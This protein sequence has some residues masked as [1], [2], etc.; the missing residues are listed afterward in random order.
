MAED[1][2]AGKP[3]ATGAVATAAASSTSSSTPTATPAGHAARRLGPVRP[4]TSD[5]TRYDNGGPIFR[6]RTTVILVSRAARCRQ[7]RPKQRQGEGLASDLVR[8]RVGGPFTQNRQREVGSRLGDDT[9]AEV[10]AHQRGEC[11]NAEDGQR[12]AYCR[13]GAQLTARLP[14]GAIRCHTAVHAARS[15]GRAV[16]AVSSWPGRRVRL[17]Q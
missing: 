9:Q 12:A 2:G 1:L 8:A 10:Q 4:A 5:P 15:S 6:R 17:G 16:P 3:P 11:G 13:A 7:P 14:G